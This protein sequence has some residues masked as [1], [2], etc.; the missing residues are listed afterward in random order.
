MGPPKKALP[1]GRTGVQLARPKLKELDLPG[2]FKIVAADQ[3]QRYQLGAQLLSVDEPIV[4]IPKAEVPESVA[5]LWVRANQGH[6][7]KVGDSI[8]G[9]TL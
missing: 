6:T 1:F 4:P 8:W 5:V 3:K 9:H 7:L 2:L